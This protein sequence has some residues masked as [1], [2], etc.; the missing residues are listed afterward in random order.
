MTTTQ[1]TSSKD[2]LPTRQY[3]IDWIRVLAFCILIF[4]HTGM[5]F[6]KWGWHVKNNEISSAIEIPME[7]LHQWRLPLLFFISGVG[8]SFAMKSRSGFQF[9]GERTQ[10]LFIPLIF[11]IFVIVP[12]QIYFERLQRHQFEGSYWQ[13]YP[14]VFE[15]VPYP[16]GNFSWHHLWF[17]VY[18][19]VFS[20]I[21]TPFFSWVKNHG[22]RFITAL[23]G[24]I[25]TPIGLLSLSFFP[26]LSY[27]TLHQH[28][29]VTNNLIADWYNFTLSITLF[30]LGY[31]IGKSPQSWNLMEKYRV[32]YAFIG[33]FITVFRFSYDTIYGGIPETTIAV[34]GM[35]GVLTMVDLWATIL[36]IGGF[37][38][39]YLNFNNQFVAY[40]NQAVYPFYILHQT[41]TVALGYYMANLALNLWFKFVIIAF[42]TFFITWGI[43]HF[44]IRPIGLFR[45]LFGVKKQ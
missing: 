15:F 16:E 30:L 32:Q 12:P 44:L 43:Y 4:F 9:I 33:L 42:G 35:N 13:F 41:I 24:W 26:M 18:L 20:V 29:R 10:R 39:H 31:L 19:W 25:N 40:G 8:V 6:V 17:V 27:W 28:W 45:F 38:K 14:K 36:A 3:Y 7:W 1:T 37:A 11:G 22:H 5:F 21:C 2:P 34:L 23:H